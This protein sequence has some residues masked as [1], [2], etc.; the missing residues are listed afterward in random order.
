MQTR[1]EKPAENEETQV[2]RISAAKE[3]IGPDGTRGH[4]IKHAGTGD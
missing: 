3:E 1:Q 2:D 4:A